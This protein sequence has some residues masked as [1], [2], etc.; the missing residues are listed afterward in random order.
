MLLTFE[1]ASVVCYF[2]GRE[3]DFLVSVKMYIIYNFEV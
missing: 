1:P 2:T 3:I